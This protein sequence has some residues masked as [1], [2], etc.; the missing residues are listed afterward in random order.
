VAAAHPAFAVQVVLHD[1]TPQSGDADAE[2]AKA[3]VKALVAAGAN[4]SNVAQ[5][6]VGTGAPV[7]DP[8]DS[9]VRGRNERLDVVFVAR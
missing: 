9:R 6:P 5:E 2:R 7:A 4:A 3:A 8:N 1:A